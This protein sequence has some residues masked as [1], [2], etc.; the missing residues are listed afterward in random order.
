LKCFE[1]GIGGLGETG[2]FGAQALQGAEIAPVPVATDAGDGGL[3]QENRF[4]GVGGDDA[5]GLKAGGTCRVNRGNPDIDLAGTVG[6]DLP[7]ERD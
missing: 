6:S 3:A 7:G 2:A 4:G 5:G 1:G